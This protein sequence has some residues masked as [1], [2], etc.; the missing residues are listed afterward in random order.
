MVYACAGG[1][2]KTVALL[3][4]SGIDVNARY[5]NGLTALMWAAGY[6]NA[7]TI[8]VLLARGADPK[9]K[10]A[11]DL[12]ARQIAGMGS[13]PQLAAVSEQAEIEIARAGATIVTL[14][15]S[16]GLTLLLHETL[17]RLPI[18]V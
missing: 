14:Q 13:Q 17:G 2:A 11:R 6:G 15:G 8:E 1:H 5:E 10:D 7:E 12:T 4:D 16:I 18:A 9:L 3:L